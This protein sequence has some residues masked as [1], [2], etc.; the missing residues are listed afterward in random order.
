MKTK[1]PCQ[2]RNVILPYIHPDLPNDVEAWMTIPEYNMLK[3]L[4][5]DMVY[6]EIGTFQ[7]ASTILVGQGAKSLTLIDPKLN[8]EDWVNRIRSNIEQETY[9]SIYADKSQ[10]VHDSI[11]DESIDV[12]L[13]DGN[14]GKKEVLLDYIYYWKKVKHGGYIVFHDYG[15]KE[16]K[17]V[18]QS[19]DGAVFDKYIGSCDTLIW[20]MKEDEKDE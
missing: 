3:L 16:F 8:N 17:G 2:R 6:C 10:N 7:G 9:I 20:F 12:L 11:D 14:H 4:T 5:K 15:M 1:Y 18:S 13:I 19:V